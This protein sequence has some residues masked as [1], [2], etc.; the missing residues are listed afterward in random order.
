MAQNKETTAEPLRPEE[1]L[2]EAK[3]SFLR[4]AKAFTP[5]GVVSRNPFT[6]MSC[7]FILGFGLMRLR[8]DAQKLPLLPL[9]ELGTLA[10][11][12]AL[13]NKK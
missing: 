2:I 1:E 4:S 13:S 10:A 6:S 12:Y 11:K 7:A 8:F 9:V 3:A 5:L